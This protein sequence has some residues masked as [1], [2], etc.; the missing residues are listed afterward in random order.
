MGSWLTNGTIGHFL[1]YWLRLRELRPDIM[2]GF[3][4]PFQPGESNIFLLLHLLPTVTW[5][6][7]A[8]CNTHR[9]PA[10]WLRSCYTKGIEVF[11]YAVQHVFSKTN[12]QGNPTEL[13]DLCTYSSGQWQLVIHFFFFFFAGWGAGANNPPQSL[14]YTTFTG[15]VP[16]ALIHFSLSLC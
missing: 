5:S 2:C 6:P 8:T 15:F 11:C 16:A 12:T 3:F 10:T 7:P 9:A 4:L 13:G 14:S 1:W